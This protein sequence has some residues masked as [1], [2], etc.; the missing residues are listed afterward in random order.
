MSPARTASLR[1]FVSASLLL[2][3][4]AATHAAEPLPPASA[5]KLP[6]W[7]GFNLL[8]KFNVGR[9]QPFLEADFKHISGFGF[10]FVRL[11]MDYRCWIKDGDWTQFNEKTLAEIDAAVE[12]GR[13][14]GVH[15]MLNFHRAPGYTV[16]TPKEKTDLFTDPETQRVCALHWATFAKRYKGI[17]NDRL[18]FNLMN[19]PAGVKTE[20]YVRV[21][22]QIIA[23]IRKEDPERL[24]VSDGLNWGNEPLMEA[25][26]LRIALAT[27]GYQPFELTHYKASWVNSASFPVPEWPKPQPVPGILQA[28]EKGAGHHAIAIDGP[29][30]KATELRMHVQKVSL[31]ANLVLAADGKETWAKRFECGPGEGE[32]TKSEFSE[33]YKIW[34]NIYDKDYTATIPA[35]T[36]QIT[37][38]VASGDW[39]HLTALGFKP[40][41]A[42][43][44]QVLPMSEVW[45][46]KPDAIRY[47]PGDAKGPFIGVPMNDRAGLWKRQIEPWKKAETA[48]IGV[49]V[50]EWGAFNRTPHDVTLRWAEDCLINYK[51]AGWGWALWNFRGSFGVMDSGR[52]D[53]QYEEFEGHKLDRKL[54]ELLRKY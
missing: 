2:L 31:K 19:E 42:A 53:V 26:D 22:T 16:A 12:L 9:N 11:P 24:I 18:S 21:I 14:Y 28:P 36:K 30:E 17:G 6:R 38:K 20:V 33:K 1:L 3:I 34:Q 41:G 32:W 29:F 46:K 50:G 47:A 54:L 7:R 5:Q 35:G 45:N 37:L 23:A 25:K 48:G 51:E 44:E 4:S 43:K 10:N 13:K 39:L 52:T 8:E 27:R 40:D 49:M 15:V